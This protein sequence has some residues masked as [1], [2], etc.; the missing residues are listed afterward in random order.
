MIELLIGSLIFT[1]MAL[2][3]FLPS[4]VADHRKHRNATAIAVL[5]LFLGWTFAGWVI[6]LVWALIEQPNKGAE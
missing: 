5:N 2:A 3:Y 1:T 6:A 4:I